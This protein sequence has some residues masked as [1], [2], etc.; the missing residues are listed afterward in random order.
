V[1]KKKVLIAGVSGLVGSAALAHF[2]GSGEW[3]VV[4]VSR[5]KPALPMGNATHIPV[6]LSDR[7]A[8]EKIFGAMTDVTH[9]VFTALNE[10]DD[11]IR[12]GWVDP[13]QIAKNAAM[14]VNLF[15]PLA[16][17][18]KGLQ[19]ISIMHGAKAYGMHIPGR[20]LATARYEDEPRH[21]EDNFYH[22]QQDYITAKQKGAA[23]SW[24]IWRPGVIYGVAVGA[25]MGN[26]M[27]LAVFAALCKEAGKE[28]PMPSG[29]SMIFEPVDADLLAEAL[30]WAGES[31]TARNEIFN[32]HN[33]EAFP[34][35]Q[36]F[37]VVA[38]TL[39]MKLGTPRPYDIV[40]EINALRPL[41]ADMVKKHRLNAPGN[42][43][44]LLGTSLQLGGAWT[45]D[46]PPDYVFGSGILST[47]KLRRAGFHGTIDT[48]AMFAKHIRKMQ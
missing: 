9:V 27:V 25:N 12:G 20:Q 1:T 11:D 40:A 38:E 2:A 30:A 41:W 17:S 46:V 31:P 15:D 19:H 24:T 39:G 16:A 5:R 13:N 18:A 34:V 8:C 28:L 6:D 35:Y 21:A 32:F 36:A 3:E 42:L 43:D 14:L 26:L 33:G 47:I 4:G 45:A 29:R 10:R 7:A 23:W 48:R 22:R 44:D 37:P